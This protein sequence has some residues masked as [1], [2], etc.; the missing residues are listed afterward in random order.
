MAQLLLEGFF[1]LVPLTA[2]P[3]GAR[4][5]LRQTGLPYPADVAVSRHLA[6][7]LDAGGEEPLPDALLLNGG[8][9]NFV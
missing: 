3:Q 5:A 8:S 2:R 7:F 6:A 4:S 9:Y 1:P